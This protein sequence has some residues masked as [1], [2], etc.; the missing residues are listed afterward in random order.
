MAIGTDASIDFFG[1]QDTVTAGGGTSAVN[2]GA[3]SAAADTDTWTNDDDAKYA[4]F[5]LK[6]QYPSGTIDKNGIRLYARLMNID[7]TNDEPQPDANWDNHFLG[8]FQTDAGLA[9]TTDN[10][11]TL[12]HNVR[13]PNQYTS[14]V[15]EF[16]IY[17]DC[18]VQ[19]SAGWTLKVTPITDGP[20]A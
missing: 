3:Y 4:A 13:L 15:Y 6:F 12:G 17:N 11:L 8:I 10:Y 2:D 7:G 1:T 20:H 9:V 18:G 19:M 5:A 14:Q 16:F